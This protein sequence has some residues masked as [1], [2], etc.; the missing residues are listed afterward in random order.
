MRS[1]KTDLVEH[2]R[3]FRQ[4]LFNLFD[5]LIPLLDL[6]EGTSCIAVSVRVEQLN[7]KGQ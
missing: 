7:E 3:Q 5:I 1:G 6:S 4:R 2:L